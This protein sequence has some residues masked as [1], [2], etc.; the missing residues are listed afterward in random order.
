M[1]PQTKELVVELCQAIDK[2]EREIKAHSKPLKAII[3]D[4]K[5]ELKKILKEESERGE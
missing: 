1:N 3:K 2:L 4:K 5:K